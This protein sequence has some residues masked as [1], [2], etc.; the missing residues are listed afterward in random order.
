MALDPTVLAA[1]IVTQMVGQGLLPGPQTV[2]LATAIANAVV[3]QLK[4]NAVV[5]GTCPAGGG[6]LTLGTIT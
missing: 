2:S 1:E 4:T 6:P 3:D 5:L